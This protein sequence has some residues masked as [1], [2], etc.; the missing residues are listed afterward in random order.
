MSIFDVR[1][2]VVH[3]TLMRLEQNKVAKN[4]SSND[5]Q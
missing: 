1:L 2:C 5:A 4:S 3:K